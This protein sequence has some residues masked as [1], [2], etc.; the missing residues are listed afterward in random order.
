VP[1]RDMIVEQSSTSIIEPISK[2]ITYIVLR[3]IGCKEQ[4]GD[5]VY[6]INDWTKPSLTADEDHNALIS[7][8][9]CDVKMVV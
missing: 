6:L 4:F 7:K 3:N 2:Q 5:N 8:D 1:L 9:R